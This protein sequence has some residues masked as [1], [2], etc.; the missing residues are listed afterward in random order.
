MTAAVVTTNLTADGE[1]VYPQ[2]RN[3]KRSQIEVSGTFGSGT[4][5]IGYDD[6]AGNFVAFRDGNGTAITCTSAAG[7][8]V[9]MP[10]SEKLC[11]KVTGST[12]ASI[13]IQFKAAP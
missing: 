7:W 4:V 13:K 3:L 12:A 2:V 6:G 10:I 1:Y 8:T 9:D 5:T 11:I